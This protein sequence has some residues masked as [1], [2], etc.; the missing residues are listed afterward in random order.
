M[1]SRKVSNDARPVAQA[2]GLLTSFGGALSK[3]EVFRCDMC[4]RAL[5]QHGDRY[6]MK[7]DKVPAFRVGRKPFDLCPECAARLK[8]KLGRREYADAGDAE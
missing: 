5:P 3:E 6:V 8:V 1:R 2:A 4:G 7:L